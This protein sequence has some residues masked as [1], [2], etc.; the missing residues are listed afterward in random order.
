MV[1]VCPSRKNVRRFRW[2]FERTWFCAVRDWVL[3]FFLLCPTIVLL[4]NDE[5]RNINVLVEDFT[6]W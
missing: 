2:R 4:I 5:F 1:E 6:L 3:L